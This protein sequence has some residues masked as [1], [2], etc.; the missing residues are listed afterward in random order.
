MRFVRSAIL[1][2]LVSGFSYA[3]D[4]KVRVIDPHSAVVPK[5]RVSLLDAS[6][7]RVLAVSPASAAGSAAFS[8]IS[9]GSYRVRVLAPGF[10]ERVE[11]VE[12]GGETSALIKLAIAAAPETVVVTAAAA[13]LPAEQSGVTVGT[14]GTETLEALNA[15]DLGD[16]LRFAPGVTL[17]DAGRR[18]G[19]STLFV[20]GGESRYN[21]VLIDDVP[22]NDAGGTF[23]FGVVSLDQ[24]ERVEL[25]RG[26]ASSLYGSDAMTSVVQAWSAPG[27]TPVPELRFGAEGGTFGTARGYASVAAARGRFDYNL[28]G[29]QFNTSGQGINDEYSNASQG[30]NFGVRLAE[31]VSLRLRA[32][33][34]NSRTG[35]P[36]N[37]WFNNFT[38]IP[39]DS[40]QYARQNNFLASADLTVVGPNN[41]IHRFTG[42]EYNHQRRNSDTV[43]DAGR[44]FDDPFDS[45]TKFNRAGL[46]YTSEI[47]PREWTR[48]VF[49]YHFEDENGFI[50]SSFVS[51]GFPGATHTHGLR[52]NHA[53]FGEQ[54]VNW[55]RL[56][57]LAGARY[58]H[59]ESFGNKVLPRAT[60][61]L[62]ALRGG[63]LFSGTRLRGS[64]SEGIKAPTFEESFGVTGSF[65]TIGN[66]DLR[67]ERARSLEGGFQ[68]SLFGGRYA[69]AATY[70][71]NRFTDQIQF[72]FDAVASQ[73]ININR[74]L[75]HGAEVELSGRISRRLSLDG[76]YVYT[77]T[78]V[79]SAPLCT[80]GFGC[81]A[82]GEPLLRR[83]KHSG[84]LLL[85]YNG[86][87]WG[88]SLGGTFVG[89]RSDSD[90]FFG[91]IPP[92]NYAAGYARADVSAWYAINR[93]V[94][95][96]ANIGNILN[97]RYNDVVGYP[98]LKANFRAG[99]RFRIGG[100]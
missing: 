5:A 11:R 10:A 29:E 79:L 31:N 16:A 41:W 47:S 12:V 25:L 83:P 24:I 75:A 63:S 77:S 80:P 18:G 100:E 72:K 32:R 13:P 88:G 56:S 28:F 96:Y 67:P 55:R 39:P 98:G 17:A 44:P 92:V 59:N 30:A 66:P 71:N 9:A 65:V 69:L 52:R 36:S 61:T 53:V 22:V 94:T 43:A 14:L 62:L 15:T 8:G 48:T 45:R 40:D 73:Y 33:H 84:N 6:G 20:R 89:R 91:A 78:Q 64:Y 99:M 60:L 34:S 86:T 2:F 51:F 68:Q 81:N 95:A 93:R 76:A 58:E 50:D 27:S 4:L 42:F 19:L 26:A 90:F 3:A 46:Q 74:S 70:F 1:L 82:A 57:L 35:V 7:G 21:K 38:F 23:D 87:R 49:G 37:W 85:T 54:F 97:H